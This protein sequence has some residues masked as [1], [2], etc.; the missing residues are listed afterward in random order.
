MANRDDHRG[1]GDDRWRAENR[2][3]EDDWR[4]RRGQDDGRSFGG[5]RGRYNSDEARYGR[6][7]RGGGQGEGEPWRRERYGSRYDQDRTGYG[8]GYDRQRGDY[9]RGQT[10]YGGQ[11]YGMESPR[12]ETGRE[13]GF[14]GGRERW[15][16][17]GSAPY[18]DL[19]FNAR[20]SG[21]EEFGAPHD[22]AYHPPQG[23]EFDPDYLH[24]RDEQLR[25]HDR[26]YQD[27]R[28]HQQ[29]QYD[30]DYRSYRSEQRDTFGKTFHA[31][32]SE[33]GASGAGAE[34]NREPDQV[35]AVTDGAD[36]PKAHG[37]ED[38]GDQSHH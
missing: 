21:V 6:G 3:H 26:D 12:R 11:E 24:W 14:G 25:A 5:D 20:A 19:E 13:R 18:G 2:N 31:W 15:R 10:G 29:N 30:E 17:Q 23:H 32:R 33:R 8:S 27:W 38:R 4:R 9:G 22:Y 36:G 16:A 1:F 28:R 7:A 37:D 35:K 34:F